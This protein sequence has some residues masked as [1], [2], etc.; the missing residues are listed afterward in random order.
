M[1]LN[2]DDK[3]IEKSQ[4]EPSSYIISKELRCL[5]VTTNICEVRGQSKTP[6]RIGHWAKLVDWMV[7]IVDV[8]E[9]HPRTVFLAMDFFLQ[10]IS[11]VMVSCSVQMQMLK[12]VW[13]IW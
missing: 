1:D 6:M 10:F 8:F 11:N 12:I 4:K 9:K 2:G 5:E 3:P 7:E 13:E